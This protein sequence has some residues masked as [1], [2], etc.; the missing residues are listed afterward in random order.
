MVVKKWLLE[1]Q[2]LRTSPVLSAILYLLKMSQSLASMGGDM[3]PTSCL[4]LLIYLLNV[5]PSL[6]SV[7]HMYTWCL[8]KPEEGVQSRINAGTD[9]CELPCG[10]WESNLSPLEEHLIGT[11]SPT[12]RSY[13]SAKR[14]NTWTW[15]ILFCFG[16]VLLYFLSPSSK[17][18]CVLHPA[19]RSFSPKQGSHRSSISTRHGWSAYCSA[20]FLAFSMLQPHFG[21]L[22]MCIDK[23]LFLEFCHFDTT[24]S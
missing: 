18:A 24:S 10:V 9:G 23:Y 19:S 11:I 5:L 4:S 2:D 8:Q 21:L 13:I 16:L 15:G 22:W 3:D 7:Y 6:I 17:V 14:M 20:P 12:S 1:C